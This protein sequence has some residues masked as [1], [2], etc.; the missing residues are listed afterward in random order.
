MRALVLSDTHF[1][2][3][4]PEPQLL[5]L[6]ADLNPLAGGPGVPPAP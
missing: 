2:S 1:G 6:L 5:Q 4:A 3:E